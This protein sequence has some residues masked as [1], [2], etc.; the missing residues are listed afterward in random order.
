LIFP[1]PDLPSDFFLGSFSATSISARESIFGPRSLVISFV[2]A[3]GSSVICFV[4]AACFQG[5]R[6]GEKAIQAQV[7]SAGEVCSLPPLVF[8]CSQFC[9][10]PADSIERFL[11]SGPASGRPE[12]RRSPCTPGAQEQAS[13]VVFCRAPPFQRW[14]SCGFPSALA[15]VLRLLRAHQGALR[16]FSSGVRPSPVRA[17][18]RVLRHRLL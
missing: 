4:R 14:S 1:A 12:V 2:A 15:L 18:T 5:R 7:R 13:G 6:I 10:S 16:L 3:Q 17:P 9:F 11:V 8:P